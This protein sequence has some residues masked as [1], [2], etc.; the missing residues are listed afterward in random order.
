MFGNV[1][2]SG[3]AVFALRGCEC[4]VFFSFVYSFL[5]CF[6]CS[7]DPLLVLPFLFLFSLLT[8]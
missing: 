2:I 1:N 3:M 6:F 4:L 8:T 7:F 5:R